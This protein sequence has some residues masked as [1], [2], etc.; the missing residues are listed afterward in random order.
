MLLIKN[1][2]IPFKRFKAIN[3]CGILFC[4]EQLNTIDITHEQIHTKQMQEML[5]V[6]FYLWYLVEYIIRLFKY[7]PHQAY[8]HILFEQEA[9]KY[10]VDNNYLNTRKHYAWLC[11]MK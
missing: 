10:E 9:Y 7:N 3:I 4:R 1:K 5:Y 11:R 2:I 8:R 6:F